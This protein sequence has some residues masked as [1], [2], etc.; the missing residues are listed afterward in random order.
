MATQWTA[1]TV[2]GQILTAATLNTIGAVTVDYT[3]TLTQGV[4][5]TKTVVQARYF[6]FQKFVQGTIVLNTTSAGTAGQVVA[7]GLPISARATSTMIAFGYIYDA[8]TNIMYN[9]TGYT[10]SGTT[11]QFFYQAGNP[12]GVSPAI[13]LAASDQISLN[14]SYE[15]A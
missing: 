14:F 7:V 15:I 12:F 6:Q 3:P 10:A 8:N 13:T 5:V 11:L 1:G 2:S 4:A 9:V